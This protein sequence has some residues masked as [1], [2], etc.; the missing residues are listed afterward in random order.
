[1]SLLPRAVDLRIADSLG[2]VVS[3]PTAPS[4]PST[5]RTRKARG[6]KFEG[7]AS[8]RGRSRASP[9]LLLTASIKS[10]SGRSWDAGPS[11]ARAPRSREMGGGDE[12]QGAD[13]AFRGSGPSAVPRQKIPP[14]ILQMTLIA[15]LY[16]PTVRAIR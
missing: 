14:R 16:L 9:V 10:G 11:A 15:F 8:S 7:S 3:P 6:R 2:N 4:A 5:D 1:V 12:R 13:E